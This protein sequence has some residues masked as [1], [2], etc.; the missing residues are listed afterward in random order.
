M[1]D[2]ILTVA[3][4][5]GNLRIHHQSMMGDIQE[6]FAIGNQY[7]IAEG[8]SNLLMAA[9]IQRQDVAEYIDYVTEVNGSP[10]VERKKGKGGGTFAHLYV[11]MDAASSLSPA[12]KHEIYTAFLTHK[13]LEWREAS[14]ED[15]KA[16]NMTLSNY[17][18]HL[19]GKDAHQGHFIQLAKKIRARLLPEDH[20]G[21]NFADAYQL[22]ERTR[23]ESQ[24][25]KL[26]EL[27][28]VRDWEHLQELIEKV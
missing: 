22:R 7:R 25:I 21:W 4:K 5:G 27:G 18:Q 12:F 26:I 16:L 9:W 11:L 3:F 6:V 23:I 8:K 20:L 24:L 10:A 17:S 1:K 14:G 13:L 19:L 15:F 2:T 28:L